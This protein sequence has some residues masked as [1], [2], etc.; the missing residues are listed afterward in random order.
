MWSAKQR[1]AHH[2][3]QVRR[4]SNGATRSTL[5][6]TLA[7]QGRLTRSGTVLHKKDS[8]IMLLPLR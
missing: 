8:E 4:L 6:A 5:S 2:G 1:H 7:A 3:E